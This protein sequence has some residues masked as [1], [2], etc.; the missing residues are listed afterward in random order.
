M[1]PTVWAFSKDRLKMVKYTGAEVKKAINPI[2]VSSFF[3]QDL[4][5]WPT[6][7]LQ[8]K[9]ALLHKIL[10]I[11]QSG[12][13]GAATESRPSVWLL[14]AS[15]WQDVWRSTGADLEEQMH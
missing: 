10:Q 8:L 4:Y 2:T 1:M 14:L 6:G 11:T 7:R 13:S 15:P 12:A 9:G 5:T 3:D